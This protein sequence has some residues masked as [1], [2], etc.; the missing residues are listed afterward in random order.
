MARWVFLSELAASWIAVQRSAGWRRCLPRLPS[1][2]FG[3]LEGAPQQVKLPSLPCLQVVRFPEALENAL[4]ELMP[5]RLTEYL[6]DLSD[7]FTG[8]YTECK[9]GLSWPSA[10][11]PCFPYREI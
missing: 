11:S 7:K 4:D 3:F 2:S 1:R 8:F 6:Y 5:N 9:V 10:C